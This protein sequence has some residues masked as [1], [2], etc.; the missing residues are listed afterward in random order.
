VSPRYAGCLAA[1]FLVPW[2]TSGRPKT[3]TYDFSPVTKRVQAWIDRGDYPGA[4]VWIA[5]GDQVVYA[6]CFGHYTPQSEVLIA[7][8]GKWLAAATIMSL[9]DAGTLSLDDPAS[10]WL[11]EF[12]DDPKGAATIRQMLSH[13]SGYPPY[14]PAQRGPRPA[15]VA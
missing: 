10:K 11:P 14:P 3:A 6:R 15:A 2:M 4:A 1:V 13:T 5:K 12:K 7:S 9:V 8:A